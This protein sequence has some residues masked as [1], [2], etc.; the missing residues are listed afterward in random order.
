MTYTAGFEPARPKPYDIYMS[1]K[2]D[3][4]VIPINHS[5]TLSTVVDLV[6]ALIKNL[7]IQ[8]HTPI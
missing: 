6:K 7:L 2:E 1:F 4:R 5:G 3:V 8:L